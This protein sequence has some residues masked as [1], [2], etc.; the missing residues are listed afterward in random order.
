MTNKDYKVSTIATI[1]VS[2]DIEIFTNTSP[3][4]AEK[5]LKEAAIEKF[6]EKFGADLA[7]DYSDIKL[8]HIIQGV[9]LP[10]LKKG[11]ANAKE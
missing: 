10:A 2:F 9:Y 7:A 1:E 5:E 4:L 8:G 3:F 6:N 11:A